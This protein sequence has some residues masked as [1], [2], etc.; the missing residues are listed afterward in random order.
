MKSL[1]PQKIVHD[2]FDCGKTFPNKPALKV[3]I[4]YYHDDLPQA[5]EQKCCEE[6]EFTCFDC[7]KGF[8]SKSSLKVHE[9]TCLPKDCFDCGNQFKNKK[10]LKAHMLSEHPN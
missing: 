4:T 8:F 5:H 6:F 3:H 10:E 2:C 9:R 7:G 1:P